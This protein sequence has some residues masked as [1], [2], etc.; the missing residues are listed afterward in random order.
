MLIKSSSEFTR[1]EF[2]REFT[3]ELIATRQKQMLERVLAQQEAEYIRRK[4]EIEM[5]RRK[6]I[7]EEMEARFA[8]ERKARIKAVKKKEPSAPPPRPIAAP[9][10]EALPPIKPPEVPPPVAALPPLPPVPPRPVRPAPPTEAAR[11]LALGKI[12]ALIDDPLVT[13][14]ECQG[15]KKNIIIKRNQ[16]TVQTDIQLNDAEINAIIKDF[17]DKARIPLIEGMLRARVGNLQISAV[18]SKK[19]SARFI[20]T[21]TIVPELKQPTRLQPVSALERPNVPRRVPARAVPGV[22]RP[23]A[24]QP[25]RLP[26]PPQPVPPGGPGTEAIKSPL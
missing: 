17:S 6:Y 18:I 5:L 4:K 15:P 26:R 7:Q 11:A 22:R 12:Q 8:E 3:A 20:I 2:I 19:G 10:P 25:R 9:K 16:Q 24:A 23:F 14:I 13:S 21:K 1:Q